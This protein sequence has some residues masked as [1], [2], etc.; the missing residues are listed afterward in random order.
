MPR[1]LPKNVATRF[2]VL[3]DRLQTA[4][5]TPQSAT[6]EFALL[7]PILRLL[8]QGMAKCEMHDGLAFKGMLVSPEVWV[9]RGDLT[10]VAQA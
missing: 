10:E 5:K 1:G 7:I 2:R 4:C 8:L 9:V 6:D 3:N